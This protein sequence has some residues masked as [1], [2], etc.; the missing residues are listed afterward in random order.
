MKRII[1]CTQ[2]FVFC[3]VL[4]SQRMKVNVEYHKNID[5]PFFHTTDSVYNP[6]TLVFKDEAGKWHYDNVPDSNKYETQSNIILN[7]DDSRQLRF[8]K[9]TLGDA[10]SVITLEEDGPSE[11]LRLEIAVEGNIAYASFYTSTPALG[12]ADVNLTSIK[13]SLNILYPKRGDL[14]KGKVSFKAICKDKCGYTAYEGEGYFK[15]IV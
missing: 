7:N 3:L 8:G 6:M 1:L 4:H 14:L 2:F 9:F 5:H 15:F 12:K 13:L 10:V 11:L